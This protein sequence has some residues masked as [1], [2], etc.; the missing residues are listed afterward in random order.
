[1]NIIGTNYLGSSS[2]K[3]K[4]LKEKIEKLEFELIEKKKFDTLEISSSE[5]TMEI[6]SSYE[7]INEI[8]RNKYIYDYDLRDMTKHFI[9]KNSKFQNKPSNSSMGNNKSH[10]SFD[11]ENSS[12][13]LKNPIKSSINK[14][15]KNNAK[16]VLSKISFKKDN[17]QKDK[18]SNKL[19]GKFLKSIQNSSNNQ[20]ESF[21]NKVRKLKPSES[22]LKHPQSHQSK[23]FPQIKKI[24]C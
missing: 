21:I 8:S 18:V 20:A 24:F 10:S 15:S 1:M 9:I 14:S 2:D 13:Y 12:N 19:M 11:N 7:N 6:Y 16:G 4:D 22:H 17:N 3:N 23:Y 5:S